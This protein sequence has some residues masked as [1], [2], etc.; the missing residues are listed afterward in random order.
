MPLYIL[1][2]EHEFNEIILEKRLNIIVFTVCWSLGSKMI[3]STIFNLFLN[4]NLTD[5][6]FYRI[7]LNENNLELIQRL[8]IVRQVFFL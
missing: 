7:D 6:N 5:I 2:K 3:F 4:Q 1:T 8:N